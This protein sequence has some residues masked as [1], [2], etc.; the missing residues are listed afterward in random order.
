MNTFGRYFRVTTWGESHGPAVGAVIDGCPPGLKL[1][2]EDIQSELDLRR[3]GRSRLTSRRRE[4]DRIEILSGLFEGRTTGT[5]ISLLIRNQDVRS[6]DYE[7]LKDVYRPGHADYT[8]QVKYGHRDWRGG[9]RSSGRETAARVAAGAVA[10]K[11]LADR[12]VLVTAFARQ[13]GSVRL[14]GE[15]ELTIEASY[16]EAL[17]FRR[18]VYDSD[19]RCPDAQTAAAMQAE[20]EEAAAAGD[21]L[22]GIVEIWALGLPAGLGEPLFGRL[23]AEIAAAL[24]SVGAVKGVEFGDGFA[25]ASM[26]GSQANDGFTI[27][28]GRVRSLSNH[29]GGVLGGI[30]SGEPLLVRAVIKPTPS[31]SLPQQSVNLNGEPVELSIAGRHD[32]CI[33]L[34]AVPV[35]EHMINLVLID[36]LLAARPHSGSIQNKG[37]DNG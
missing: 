20:V 27:R 29:A 23:D 24:L 10:Q 26:R 5:P 14:G 7:D 17:A 6:S 19:L 9:G 8:Y 3:P 11:L 18:R 4:Q 22:G 13:V 28:D 32:P 36:A 33:V 30:S 37:E 31:I 35:L 1:S 2:A 34:R 25:L 12:S 21:S 16:P 15:T